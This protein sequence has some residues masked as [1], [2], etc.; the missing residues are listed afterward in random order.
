MNSQKNILVINAGSATLKFKVYDQSL[1]ELTG[2]IVERIG[3]KGS[4]FSYRVNNPGAKTENLAVRVKN[5][6]QA[7][8]IVLKF[9]KKLG[10]NIELV[11][12]RVVHGGEEFVKPTLVDKAVLK[13]LE[14]YN[15][16]APLH[17]PLNLECIKVCQKRLKRVKN[18]AVFDTAFYHTVPDYIYLYALPLSYYRHYHIRRYGF[19]GIAHNYALLAAAKKLGKKPSELNLINCHLGSGSSIT[20]IKSGK[21]LDTTMGFTPLEGL[22][23]STRAG[24]LDATLPLYLMKNLK[25]SIKKIEKL[26]NEESGLL[27]IAGTRDMREVLIASGHKVK[28]FKTNRLYNSQEKKRAKLALDMFVYDVQR[29]LNS[30]LG[31]LGQVDAIVF[32][33]GIGE[34]SQVIRQLVLKGV[35]WPNKLKTLVVS[36]N[37]EMMIAQEVFKK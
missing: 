37:E 19:H 11:G 26:F 8:K 1:K 31:L 2:G 18:I 27:G 13:K 14:K 32:T 20:A 3:L 36:V 22:T 34:R 6:S 15:Q 17:N 35:K 16:L 5:H 10:C 9:L 28:D 23:M 30:Y 33:G 21:A 24:D 7:V 29:Y 25:M 12:H 4:F